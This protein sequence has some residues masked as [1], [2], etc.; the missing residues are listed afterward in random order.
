MLSEINV[1][2]FFLGIFGGWWANLEN[3]K[4]AIDKGICSFARMSMIR[5]FLSANAK[6]LKLVFDIRYEKMIFVN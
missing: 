3:I 6:S 1:L 5:D 2:N 4:D